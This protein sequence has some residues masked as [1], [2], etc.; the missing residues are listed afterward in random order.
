MV[1]YLESDRIKL[2][3]FNDRYKTAEYKE[4]FNDH[5]TTRFLNSGRM[6]IDPDYFQDDK[7]IMWAITIKEPFR[8]IGTITLHDIDWIS[9]HGTTGYLIGDKEYWGKGIATEVIGLVVDYAFGR[10]GLRQIFAGVVD[11]NIGSSKALEK[12]GFT[13]Y[14]KQPENYYLEGQYL[15]TLLYVRSKNR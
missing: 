1:S 2:I 15:D 10:I 5:E 6:P 4:W 12:N 9:R 13:N 14:A 11:G 7:N 8:F 3:R